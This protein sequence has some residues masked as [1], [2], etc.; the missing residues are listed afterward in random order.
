VYI[1]SLKGFDDEEEKRV[2]LL[3]LLLLLVARLASS[4]RWPIGGASMR[5][6]SPLLSLLLLLLPNRQR[7]EAEASRF[8][9]LFVIRLISK[10]ASQCM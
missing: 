4:I 3:L 8:I 6:D 7:I 5:I 2:L 10:T 9:C 1:P